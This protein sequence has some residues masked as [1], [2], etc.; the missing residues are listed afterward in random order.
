MGGPLGWG[1]KVLNPKAGPRWPRAKER[2]P[3]LEAGR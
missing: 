3:P 2:Q 1:V